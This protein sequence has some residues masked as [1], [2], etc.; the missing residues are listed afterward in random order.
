MCS[1]LSSTGYTVADLGRK[2]RGHFLLTCSRRLRS[3]E[4]T[5]NNFATKDAGLTDFERTER[6]PKERNGFVSADGKED[7]LE[8]G[9]LRVR[10]SPRRQSFRLSNL[11]IAIIEAC[12]VAA[13]KVRPG[14]DRQHDTA[15]VSIGVPL[16]IRYPK[17]VRIDVHGF[18]FSG[19]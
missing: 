13:F 3:Y 10:H 12:T 6:R 11:S 5:R 16:P 18:L 15:F 19:M 1:R 7:R 17:Y 14:F 4:I 2:H 8:S 9:S